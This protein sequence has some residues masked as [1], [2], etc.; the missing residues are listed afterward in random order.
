MHHPAGGPATVACSSNG[1]ATVIKGTCLRPRKGDSQQLASNCCPGLMQFALCRLVCNN[2]Q[3]Y[4]LDLWP[5]A[6][7]WRI[8]SASTTATH[9]HWYRTVSGSPS[10]ELLLQVALLCLVYICSVQWPAHCCTCQC[11]LARGLPQHPRWRLLSVQG[12]VD[13]LCFSI[14]CTHFASI[15]FVNACDGWHNTSRHA[16]PSLH[17][18]WV[19]DFTDYCQNDCCMTKHVLWHHQTF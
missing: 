15:H 12:K 7:R 5:G 16:R 2:S 18:I 3:S 1:W 10:I 14:G 8:E 11:H 9:S 6:N 13:L 19:F 4:S 17:G